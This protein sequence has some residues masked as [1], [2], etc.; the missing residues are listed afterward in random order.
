M[1]GTLVVRA[2]RGKGAFYRVDN[3]DL[4]VVLKSVAME[5]LK[6]WRPEEGSEFIIM[7][8]T[9]NIKL[10]LPLEAGLFEVVRDLGLRKEGNKAVFDL[11]VYVVSFDNKW[12]DTDRYVD[13]KIYV[14]TVDLGAESVR[15]FIASWALGTVEGA[16]EGEEE[17]LDEEL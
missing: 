8:D 6:E 16:G 3:R 12:I 11:P 4:Y 13:N 2:E 15:K 17:E 14:V 10:D 9:L 1:P 7:S 5:A